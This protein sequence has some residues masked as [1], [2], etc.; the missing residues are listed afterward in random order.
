MKKY[1]L[2]LGLLI[3]TL[4]LF[5]QE[6]SIRKSICRSFLVFGRNDGITNN[7]ET[8]RNDLRN[9]VAWDVNYYYWEINISSI[10]LSWLPVSSIRADDTKTRMTKAPIKS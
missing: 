1:V 2:L 10:L 7:S 6:A 3:Q 4:S 8:Y 5:A 9:G